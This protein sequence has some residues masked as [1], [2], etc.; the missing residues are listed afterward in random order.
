[1]GNPARPAVQTDPT[2]LR[3]LA[4][5]VRWKLIDVLASEGTAT[6]TRC[7]ELLGE[8][9]ATC[10]YH[11]GILAKYGYI[12]RVPGREWRDKPWR[13]ANPDLNL[14]SAGLDPEGAAA[15]RAA[16]AAFLDYEMTVLKESLRRS[17]QEPPPW[18]QANKIMGAT[19]WVTPEECQEAAAEIAQ[20]LDKYSGPDKEKSR[21]GTRAVRLFAAV[22]VSAPSNQLAA[23]PAAQ[24]DG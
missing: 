13:L 4:H 15:S 24:P 10:S 17:E 19:A 6:A 14:S 22:A 20:I 9:T 18:R 7:S 5:P 21:E 1:M 16:A 2:A 23:Q 3:A 8:S 12:T 11:L